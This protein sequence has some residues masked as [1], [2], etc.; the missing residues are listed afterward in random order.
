MFGQY[1][2]LPWDIV[3]S[4]GYRERNVWSV[5]NVT[6]GHSGLY[7]SYRRVWSVHNVTM[8]IVASTGHIDVFG[9]YIMLPW[10]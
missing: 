5:H 9:K 6:M 8:G 3:V 2:M 7:W 10:A 1:I 4:T